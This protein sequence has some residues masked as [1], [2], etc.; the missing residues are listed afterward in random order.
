MGLLFLNWLEAS[1]N[2]NRATRV[3]KGGLMPIWVA[4][5]AV[6]NVV[7]SMFDRVDR[8]AAFYSNVLL[9]ARKY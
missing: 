5:C 3:L 9:M 7:G 8:T 1:T 4:A 2:A 6:V